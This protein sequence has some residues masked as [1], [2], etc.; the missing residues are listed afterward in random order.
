MILIR[1]LLMIGSLFQ[2]NF[3]RSSFLYILVCIYTWMWSFFIQNTYIYIHAI[4][5]IYIC[6]LYSIYLKYVCMCI[7][8]Y[9]YF[10]LINFHLAT[11]KL[12]SS[13]DYWDLFDLGLVLMPLSMDCA[14]S[15]SM[16]MVKS[17][18]HQSAG[19]AFFFQAHLRAL[20]CFSAKL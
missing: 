18:K 13:H 20:G 19:F 16:H 12:P 7:Y 6:T 5:Y 2:V 9:I 8:I 11:S 14:P 15:Q 4:H 10:L 3:K 1:I 17:P